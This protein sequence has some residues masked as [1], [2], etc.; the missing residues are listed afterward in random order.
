MIKRLILTCLLSLLMVIPA[1]AQDG[2]INIH[3]DSQES[4]DAGSIITAAQPLIDRGAFVAIYLVQRGESEA[5]TEVLQE[6]GLI[7]GEN[8]RD[9]VIAIF[10]SLDDHHMEMAYGERWESVL[11]PRSEGILSGA[12]GPNLREANPTLGFART[13]EATELAF[14]SMVS[15][16]EVIGTLDP[17]ATIVYPTYNYDPSPESGGGFPASLILL[18]LLGGGGYLL[19]WVLRQMGFE[20]N[21]GN[22]SSGTPYYKSSWT[23]SRPSS[24]SRSSS[25]SSRGSFSGGSRRSGKW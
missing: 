9:D 3:N 22:G 24:S 13:L 11:H 6:D 15:S 8:V 19:T 21:S 1:Y 20:V 18:V 4:L 23:S 14:L 12:L 5:F 10:V 2:S 16:A 7:Q 17:N 25:S